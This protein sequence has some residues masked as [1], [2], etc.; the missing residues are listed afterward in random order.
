MLRVEVTTV[1][2]AAPAGGLT[3]AGT[4]TS[5][6]GSSWSTKQE[7]GCCTLDFRN[8]K[9]ESPA[10]TKATELSAV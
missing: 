7:Q 3:G 6:R 9:I 1:L 2:Q 4:G 10:Y 8:G 5:L